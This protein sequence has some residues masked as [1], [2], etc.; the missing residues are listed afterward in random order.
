MNKVEEI[1][2]KREAESLAVFEELQKHEA[3]RAD[4]DREFDRRDKL[5]V[6]AA[7]RLVALDYAD[8][9]MGATA[10]ME[11]GV[12][13]TGRDGFR[14]SWCRRRAVLQG[15]IEAINL[16]VITGFHGWVLDQTQRLQNRINTE[17]DS[18]RPTV[19]GAR[20]IRCR[21]NAQA[22]AQAKDALWSGLKAVQSLRLRPLLEVHTKINEVVRAHE[23][24]ILDLPMKTLDLNES[25]HAR[26]QSVSHGLEQEQTTV[27]YRDGHRYVT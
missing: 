4:M 5:C 27:T 9:P 2:A 12:L 8:S 20:V 17:Y 18:F 7:R 6:D 19:D 13:R 14:W 15:K 3:T 23:D 1:A 21:S 11:V 10:R 22:V 24:A 16:P 26:L 25:E